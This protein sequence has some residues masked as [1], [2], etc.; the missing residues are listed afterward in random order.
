MKSYSKAYYQKNK[1]SFLAKGKIYRKTHGYELYLRNKRWREQNPLKAKANLQKWR[2]KLW[3]E[4]DRLLG[5]KCVICGRK[6]TIRHEIHGKKH[7]NSL[8]YIIKHYKDFVRL[9]TLCHGS[10][11]HL[12]SASNP[13]LQKFLK[14]LRC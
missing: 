10:I 8:L 14:L 6:G 1:K 3:T 9:C 5:T 2:K 13:N 7:P 12:R 4:I 11:H